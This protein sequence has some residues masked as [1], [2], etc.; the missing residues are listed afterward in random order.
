MATAAAR[1]E[2]AVPTARR[3]RNRVAGKPASVLRSGVTWIVV[4][5]VLLAGL[6]ALNVA[7]L[8]LNVRIDQ[9]SRERVTLRAETASLSSRLSSNA[10]TPRIEG[11]ARRRLG[12]VPASPEATTYIE[13][14]GP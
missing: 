9:L 6:V 11:L 1:H 3:R 2:A 4:L 10:A 13:L 14:G 12:L 5:A 7:V 8:Q